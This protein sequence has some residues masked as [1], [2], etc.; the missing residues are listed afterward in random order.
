M[1]Q[2]SGYVSLGSGTTVY[3]AVNGF[4]GSSSLYI[5]GAQIHQFVDLSSWAGNV[6]IVGTPGSCDGTYI[7]QGVTAFGSSESS[8]ELVVRNVDRNIARLYATS[9]GYVDLTH[10]TFSDS[11]LITNNGYVRADHLTVNGVTTLRDLGSISVTDSSLSTL[12]CDTYDA[13]SY[14]FTNV[15]VSHAQGQC[16]SVF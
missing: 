9:F 7:S 11:A 10:V 8:G 13:A 3:G 5:C 4:S 12:H 15:S 2:A 1:L 16:Q 14:L 6:E